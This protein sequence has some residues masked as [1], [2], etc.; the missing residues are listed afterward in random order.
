MSLLD[1]I[2]CSIPVEN[3]TI[4]Q[5][6]WKMTITNFGLIEQDYIRCN[7]LIM[8]AKGNDTIKKD[9]GLSLFNRI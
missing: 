3:E 9:N 5:R 6:I 8:I 2:D 7:G 1:I 4:A